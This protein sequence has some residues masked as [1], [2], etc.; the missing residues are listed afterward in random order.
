MKRDISVV[1]VS[2]SLF[3]FA[4]AGMKGSVRDRIGNNA[5]SFLNESDCGLFVLCCCGDV[6]VLVR[7]RTRRKHLICLFFE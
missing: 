4:S 2:F 6:S 7:K 1:D 5:E 3:L